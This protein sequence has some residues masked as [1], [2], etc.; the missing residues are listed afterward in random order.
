MRDRTAL[1][2]RS[3]SPRSLSALP[4]HNRLERIPHVLHIDHLAALQIQL[5]HQRRRRLARG[6]LPLHLVAALARQV[7]VRA[8]ERALDGGARR[9]AQRLAARGGLGVEDEHLVEGELLRPDERLGEAGEEREVGAVDEL[10][11]RG[12]V[13]GELGLGLVEDDALGAD[14][15]AGDL[16]RGCRRCCGAG[17]RRG[18]RHCGGGR[19]RRQRRHTAEEM[20]LVFE[21]SLSLCLIP[22]CCKGVNV[23]LAVSCILR[24]V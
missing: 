9:P 5:I 8:G 12:L 24:L 19:G 21:K 6:R 11:V 22:V 4:P 2:A 17:R 14:G 18:R 1:A 10:R 16:V 13:G 23:S 15:R 7:V 20:L 3:P